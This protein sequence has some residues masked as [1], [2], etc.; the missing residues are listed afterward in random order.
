[1]KLN[2]YLQYF[3]IIMWQ[4]LIC[5]WSGIIDA[6][7]TL[8]FRSTIKSVQFIRSLSENHFWKNYLYQIYINDFIKFIK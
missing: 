3:Y 4:L 8:C 1:M 5:P 6:Y 7:F 2:S